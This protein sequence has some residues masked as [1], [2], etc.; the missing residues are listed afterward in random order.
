MLVI[1]SLG[2][3]IGYTFMFA[4][5]DPG[6]M[7]YLA[8]GAPTI[9]LIMAGF[10]ILPQQNGVAKTEG[11]IEFLRTLPIKRW[12]IIMTDMIIWLCVIFPGI[13]ISML[14]THLIFDPGYALSFTILPAFLLVSITAIAIGYG[15]SFALQP[16]VTQMLSSLLMFGTLMFSPINFPIEH[17]PNWLQIVHRFLPFHTMAN[18]MRAS[19]A[20]TTYTVYA[21]EYVKLGLW[22]ALGLT[23]SISILNQTKT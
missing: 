11:Y 20:S 8:T 6:T 15:F 17:L 3:A 19:L 12:N 4:D 13:V 5:I 9:L 1:I 21:W 2:I 16:H 14:V 7:L 23:L 18:V 10:V 22:C